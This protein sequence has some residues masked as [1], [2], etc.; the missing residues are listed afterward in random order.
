MISRHFKPT[1]IFLSAILLA[2]ACDSPTRS[3]NWEGNPII[4]SDLQVGQS[5]RYLSFSLSNYLT[6]DRALEYT[7]DTLVTTITGQQEEGFLI[8]EHFVDVDIAWPSKADTVQYLLQVSNDTLLYLLWNPSEPWF[9]SRLFCPLN[10]YYHGVLTLSTVTGGTLHGL[11]PIHP[12]GECYAGCRG[13]LD[14]I[15]ILGRNYEGLNIMHFDFTPSD[16]GCTWWLYYGSYGLVRYM[17]VNP[18]TG[19]GWGW[20]LLP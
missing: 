14:D 15:E 8:T 4:F 12:D 11:E 10:Y 7:C 2:P 20:D 3:D 13:Y 16:G 5:S 9:H 17:Q 6:S 18:W 1:V 19:S